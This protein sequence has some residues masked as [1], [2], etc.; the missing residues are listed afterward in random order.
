MS[1]C[2]VAG[3]CGCWLIFGLALVVLLPVVGFYG[4]VWLTDL[5]SLLWGCLLCVGC[6]LTR[7]VY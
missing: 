2:D 5:L 4:L 3:F 7:L 6:L 1:G